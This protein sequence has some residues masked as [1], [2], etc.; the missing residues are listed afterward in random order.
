MRRFIGPVFMLLLLARFTAAQDALQL[1]VD[2]LASSLGSPV[3]EIQDL[4]SG[5]RVREFANGAI[6]FSPTTDAHFVDSAALQKYRDLGG[7]R[8]RLGYPVGDTR[9]TRDGG[10]QTTFEHGFITTNRTGDTAAEILEDI[11]LLNGSLI[12]TAIPTLSLDDAGMLTVREGV[13]GPVI[14]LTCSCVDEPPSPTS[15]RLGFCTVVIKGKGQASCASSKAS[16]CRGS[17]VFEIVD[18]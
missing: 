11:D 13:D 14:T 8:S 5:G 2:A 12:A 9:T 18:K 1:K 3:G 6:Y 16:P 4:S 10:R 15:V 17:C 7:E